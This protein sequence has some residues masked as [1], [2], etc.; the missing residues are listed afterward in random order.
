MKNLNEK[1]YHMKDK[2][3]S[4]S[5][6][7]IEEYELHD[8]E[9]IVVFWTNGCPRQ[10]GIDVDKVK[11]FAFDEV[12]ENNALP[13][14]VHLDDSGETDNKYFDF[15]EWYNDYFDQATAVRLLTHLFKA[16]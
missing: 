9:L 4:T 15:D 5:K 13:M 1:I 8:D 12:A 7:Q 11:K 16:A 14:F 2:I 10:V 6:I 3:Q